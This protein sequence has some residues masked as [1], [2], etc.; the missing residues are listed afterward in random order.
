VKKRQR[1]KRRRKAEVQRLVK[2]M[3]ARAM[4]GA[5]PDPYSDGLFKAFES[6]EAIKKAQEEA[7]RKAEA[8]QRDPSRPLGEQT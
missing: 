2:K 1:R 5:G 3:K 6:I 7:K 4:A 8:A